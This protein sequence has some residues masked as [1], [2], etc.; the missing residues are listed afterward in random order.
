MP[1]IQYFGSF[2]ELEFL[3]QTADLKEISKKMKQHNLKRK[4]RIMEKWKEVLTKV[5]NEIH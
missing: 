2:E 4:E 1:F 5:M 3:L